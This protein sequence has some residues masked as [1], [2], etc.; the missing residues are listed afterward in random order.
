MKKTIIGLMLFAVLCVGVFGQTTAA[1]WYAKGKEYQNNSDYTNA[2]NAYSEAIKLDEYFAAAYFWRGLAYEQRYPYD[3]ELAISDF[4]TSIKY[5][6]NL[7]YSYN[8]RG[9]AYADKYYEKHDYNKALA[10]YNEAIKIDPDNFTFIANRAK[11]FY[12]MEN[13]KSAVDEYT[14]AINLKPDNGFL[15]CMRGLSY[16]SLGKW[17]NSFQGIA[18][19]AELESWNKIISDLEKSYELGFEDM[20]MLGQR[21]ILEN[22]KW[23]K[24]ISE[25][26]EN[27]KNDKNNPA[28]YETLGD[29]Y[30]TGNELKENENSYYVNGYKERFKAKERMKFIPPGT[31]VF[32]G[33]ASGS[34]GS[35]YGS[36]YVR[37]IENY[38]K[39]LSLLKNPTAW[40]CIKMGVAQYNNFSYK[41]DDSKRISRD[42]ALP[43][44]TRASTIN[45]NSK[46]S[47]LWLAYIYYQ[48][49]DYQAA[50]QAYNSALK[51]DPKDAFALHNRG[52]LYH[53]LGNYDKAI[54]DYKAAL[55]IDPKSEFTSWYLDVAIKSKG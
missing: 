45:S 2:I 12:D 47:Y 49:N 18:T 15:Y 1:E 48:K 5:N 6:Y 51:I 13:Y 46:L 44:F 9:Y 34:G 4:T 32:D 55:A 31:A 33:T 27:I 26:S 38:S 52:V 37:A 10:D 41:S 25:I 28:L 39:A 19:A 29:I 22:Y 16:S 14:K 36:D 21:Y 20:G 54:E 35:G 30:F 43:Y 24:R 40:L 3:W 17:E 23:K 7:A 42:K 11:L 53:D 8:N 50:I